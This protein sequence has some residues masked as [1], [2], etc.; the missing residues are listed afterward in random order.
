MNAPTAA[1]VLIGNE[2]LS[3]KITDTNAA[4]LIGRLRALGVALKRV[5][6]VPDEPE[7]IRHEL[8]FAAARFDH[9]FTS[10]G[11]G[12]THDD[13]TLENVAAAFDVPLRRD[14]E[15]AAMLHRHFAER[16]T[17]DHLRMADVPEGT[18]LIQG[19]EIR[20]PVMCFR[21]VYI[22]PGVPEIFRAKFDSIA[23]RFR[24]GAFALRS[25]YLNADEGT[26]APHLRVL[27][28]RF[29]VMVGS[30]PRIDAADH[31]VRVTVE[32]R[33][34]GPVDEAVEHLMA[35]LDAAWIVRVDP[36]LG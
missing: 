34:P 10:G 32:A 22:L 13:I 23:E 21:N 2:L 6:V 29:G 15:L 27:E 28:A 25:V 3:G 12:P 8:R 30:Y 5:V 4:Y 11:V 35:A 26:I 31:R 7:P 18:T 36:P 17:E 9:V 20:W 33:A 24:S 16:L 1:I 19:G 14:P